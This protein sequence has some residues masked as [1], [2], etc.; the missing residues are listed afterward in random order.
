MPSVRN[1]FKNLMLTHH[2]AWLIRL[3]FR[4]NHAVDVHELTYATALL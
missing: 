2:R 3:G 4:K 1:V